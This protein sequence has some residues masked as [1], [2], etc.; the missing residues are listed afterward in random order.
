MA[1]RRGRLHILVE[2]QTEEALVRDVFEPHLAAHGWFVTYSIV[3]TKRPAGTAAHKGGVTGWRQLEREIRLLL[4]D[5]SIGVF[6]TMFDYYGFPL[7]APGMQERP[8]TTPVD[9][10]RHV[11]RALR[12]HFADPRLVPHLVLHETEAWVYAA[13]AELGEVLGD[14]AVAMQMLKDVATSGGPE[15]IND[16]PNTAPSKRLERHSPGY[17]KTIDGPLAIA[18]LGLDGLRSQCPH[19][20]EWLRGLES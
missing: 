9:C 6:T 1:D 14:K 7:A 5:S 15:L 16:G 18:E 12:Q 19:L 2:G 3:K 17:V 13:C 20:G 11:E 4:H 8:A 10:V